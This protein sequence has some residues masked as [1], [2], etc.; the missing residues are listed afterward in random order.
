MK[1]R[2][3]KNASSPLEAK[4]F[5]DSDRHLSK[6]SCSSKWCFDY[7]RV[8]HCSSQPLCSPLRLSIRQAID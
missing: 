4:I 7:P 6:Y 1:M 8:V 2:E 3:A 5:V